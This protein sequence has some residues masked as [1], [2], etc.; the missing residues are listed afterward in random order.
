MSHVFKSA[1]I[2]ATFLVPQCAEA[3]DTAHRAAAAKALGITETQ[4]ADCMPDDAT[5]GERLSQRE[6]RQVID[7]FKAAN[8][9]LTNSKIRSAMMSLRG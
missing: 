2:V 8:P 3:Q 6:R 4:F 5:P 7:C 1:T 9:S